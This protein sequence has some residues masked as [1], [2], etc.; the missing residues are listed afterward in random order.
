[1]KTKKFT[2]DKDVLQLNS[3]FISKIGQRNNRS[4]KYKT[5]TDKIKGENSSTIIVENF[6]IS[7]L[8]IGRTI[9]PKFIKDNK[10]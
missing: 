7:C 6:N 5:K 10:S 8:I 3:Q 1:M 9:R 4:P 2:R